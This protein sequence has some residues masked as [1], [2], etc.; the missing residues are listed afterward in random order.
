MGR[1]TNW[2]PEVVFSP[3]RALSR[4]REATTGNTTALRRLIIQ[5]MTQLVFVNAYPLDS[6]VSGLAMYPVD[7][8]TQ[9]FN[10]RGQ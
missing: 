8:A 2:A 9:L 7:S 3:F 1:G 5:L 10:N 4:R 6:D